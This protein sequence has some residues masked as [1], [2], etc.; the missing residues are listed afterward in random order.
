MQIRRER[1]FRHPDSLGYILL[2]LRGKVGGIVIEHIEPPGVLQVPY[3]V[4]PVTMV[5][6]ADKVT[7]YESFHTRFLLH[8]P[9]GTGLNGLPCL[10]MA[11]GQVPEVV[12]AYQKVVSPAVRHQTPACIDLH[13]FGTDAVVGQLRMLRRHIDPVEGIGF[14]EQIH[15][16][17]YNGSSVAGRRRLVWQTEY[18]G[19]RVRKGRLVLRTYYYAPFFKIYS[20][21]FH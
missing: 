8:F 19:I 16:L 10:L 7:E 17:V 15:Q 9:Q 14:L 4:T 2:L 11:L 5:G 21:S 20:V 18:D 6:H 1:G 3:S 13:K 12:A